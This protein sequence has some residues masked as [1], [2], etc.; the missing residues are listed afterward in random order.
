ML[1][2]FTG[3][4]PNWLLFH[5]YFAYWSPTALLFNQQEGG[6]NTAGSAVGF[7]NVEVVNYDYSYYYGAKDPG[8]DKVV[9]GVAYPLYYRK[10]VLSDT[11][12]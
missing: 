10:F 2:F 9:S 12:D 8:A 6:K 3:A 4:V 11:T 1:N 7:N 5:P